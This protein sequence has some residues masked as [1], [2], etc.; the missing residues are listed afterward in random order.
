MSATYRPVQWNANKYWY[1][2]ILVLAIAAYLILFIRY[3][4]GLLGTPKIDGPILRMQ[5]FGTCAFF[6]LTI[7]LCIGPL[8]RFD[9]RFLPLLYNRRH[10][11]VLTFFVALAHLW[12]VK[13]WYFAFSPEN[14]W[15][16]LLSSSHDASSFIG[17]PIEWLGLAALIILFVMMATSHDFWLSFLTPPVWKTLH[18]GV[19]VAYGL[20]VMHVALGIMQS[21]RS[22]LYP[23]IF[24]SCLILVIGLHV[25]AAVKESRVDG[26]AVEAPGDWIAAAKLQDL[27]ENKGKTVVLPNGERAAIFRYDD[28]ISALSNVCAHQNGPLGEGCILFGFVTCPWHGF[29]YRPEDGCSPPPFTEK[30][31]TYRTK[32]EG[33]WVMIDQNALPAGT[34]TDPIDLSIR[35]R[36]E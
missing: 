3:A 9:K 1:D 29:Q 4:P 25:A 28:K 27:I 15:V 21:D 34:R 22:I 20:L 8:A 14:Q 30:V 35:G 23:I 31:P 17:F 11:G 26:K 19:Y 18:M 16:S 5:A 24:G 2:A 7:I 33:D 10:F 32:L 12:A 36:V 6:L 13:G